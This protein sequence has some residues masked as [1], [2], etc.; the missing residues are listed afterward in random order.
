[1]G[2]VIRFQT[3]NAK[4][5]GMKRISHGPRR[6]GWTARLLVAS[7]GLALLVL[8]G[9]RTP[10]QDRPRK[11]RAETAQVLQG[12]ASVIDGDT[13]RIGSERIRLNGVDAPES[14]QL[15]EDAHGAPYRCGSVAANALDAF[16][17]ASRPTRCSWVSTDRYGRF[18][19]ECA[20]ADGADVAG[21]MVSQG[22]AI[23]WVRYSGG[24][25]A[26]AQEAARA[27]KTGVW[28]GRFDLP[29]EWRAAHAQERRQQSDPQAQ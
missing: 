22:L 3:G 10:E 21:W 18:V 14:R 13:I 11:E 26:R 17:A 5:H 25:Y 4:A 9:W 15:C 27:S 24:R 6:T 8:V 1:M 28:Q 7:A 16:L 2:D 12:R 20:R 23:E 19:G 29:W